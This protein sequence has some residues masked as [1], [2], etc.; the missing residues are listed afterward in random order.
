MDKQVLLDKLNSYRPNTLMETL[1]IRYSDVDV[2][3][4]YVAATM[5]VGPTVHQPLG[6]LH[7]GANVALAESLGSAASTIWLDPKKQSAVGLEIAAN[8]IRAKRDGIVTAQGY[9]IHK[10]RKTHVWEIKIVDEQE[11]LIC[12]VKMTN[13]VIDLK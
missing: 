7:G 5:P 11:R 13:M 1:G 4:G 9:L 12:M 3:K 2:E 10:G 6:L 8:H